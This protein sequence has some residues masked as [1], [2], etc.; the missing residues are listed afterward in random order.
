MTKGEAGMQL[1]Y[2]HTVVYPVIHIVIVF[3]IS[4]GKSHTHIQYKHPHTL[5]HSHIFLFLYVY[6]VIYYFPPFLPF[7]CHLISTSFWKGRQW[8]THTHTQALPTYRKLYLP[9]VTWEVEPY[10]GLWMLKKKTRYD[11]LIKICMWLT[12]CRT[13]GKLKTLSVAVSFSY[14]HV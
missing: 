9:F 12:A 3:A 10:G 14:L 1:D 5:K 8:N 7:M 6:P 2:K 11:N 4:Q 13:P